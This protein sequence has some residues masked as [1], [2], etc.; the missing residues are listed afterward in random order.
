MQG[1]PRPPG[2]RSALE[3]QSPQRPGTG[4]MGVASGGCQGHGE[5]G[6]G[7]AAAVATGKGGSGDREGSG[8]GG[9]IRGGLEKTGLKQREG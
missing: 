6:A 8:K 1:G 2:P 9:V 4:L 3:A 5:I 7:A